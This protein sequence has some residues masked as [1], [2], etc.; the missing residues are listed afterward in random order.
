MS[1][2]RGIQWI[3]D[4][5]WSV[6]QHSRRRSHTFLSQDQSLGLR[7]KNAFLG[8]SGGPLISI[9]H[10]ISTHIRTRNPGAPFFVAHPSILSLLCLSAGRT[11]ESSRAPWASR[12]A[13]PGLCAR[14][15]VGHP[16]ASGASSRASRSSSGASAGKASPQVWRRRW[17][18]HAG[19]EWYQNVLSDMI[20]QGYRF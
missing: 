17:T 11:P 10:T 14:R 15:Y 8:G 19:R 5:L 2:T 16:S 4:V 7:P 1:G 6:Q 12:A 9:A 13:S 20:Q 3:A 18:S